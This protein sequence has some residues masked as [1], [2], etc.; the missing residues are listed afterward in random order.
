MRVHLRPGIGTPRALAGEK[1]EPAAGGGAG[2]AADLET[3]RRL[4]RR[5]RALFQLADPDAELALER[6]EPDPTRPP[7]P[8]LRPALCGPARLAGRAARPPRRRGRRVPGRRRVRPDAER[9]RA[10]AEA[11]R[12]RRSRARAL[13][14]RAPLGRAA[15]EP[16]LLIFAPGDRAPRLAWQVELDAGLLAWWNAIVDAETGALLLAENRVKE[17]NVAG[18][19][20][21]L[22]GLAEAAQRLERGREASTLSTPASSCT[23][24]PRTRRPPRRRAAGSPCSTRRTSRRPTT[25]RTIPPLF[26]ITSAEPERGACRRASTAAYG[27]REDLRPLPRPTAQLDQR[28]GRL[29]PRRGAPRCRLRERVLE[30]RARRM[31]FGDGLPFARAL[32]VVGHELTHGV[33]DSTAQAHLPEPAGRG[34]RGVRRHH[35]RDG[36]GRIEAAPD[37]LVG[38]D[39]GAPFRNMA[40]PAALPTGCGVQYPDRMSRFLLPSSPSCGPSVALD[41]GGVHFNSGIVNR[42][43]YLLA[44]GLPGAIGRRD[45]EH[46]FYRALALHLTA[47]AQFVDVR[48]GGGGVGEGAVRRGLEPGAA[49]RR[50]VR[51][52]RDLRRRGH[53]AGRAAAAA[54]GGGLDLVRALLPAAVD[55]V[56]VAARD[57]ARRPSDR[58]PAQLLRRG[59]ERSRRR[60]ATARSSGS[61]TRSTTRA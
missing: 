50:G 40:N 27:D 51:H 46:I 61:S 16:E 55:A 57:A 26:Q 11:R 15:G 58:Q 4:L 38:A 18:S 33:V 60:R 14:L 9:C 3:A 29:D 34:E 25:R 2:G 28:R 6:A 59:P 36:R 43:Y 44:A 10:H 5:Q 19:G 8:A 39:L 35:R 21:D 45:A 7:A 24:R 20:I 23:T 41:D 48:L 53:R 56:P 49:H 37:W 17:A 22:F 47:N 13:A 32:D 1:L 31:F 52:R 12:D 30:R 42:A 54:A